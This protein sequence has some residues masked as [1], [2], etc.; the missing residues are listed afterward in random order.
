MASG[1]TYTACLVLDA[2]SREWRIQLV[3]IP[4]VISEG[5]TITEALENVR[6]A[7]WAWTD[8]R[9]HAQAATFVVEFAPR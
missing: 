1:P 7:L 4:G 3:E 6:E 2:P 8:D 5:R 9:V